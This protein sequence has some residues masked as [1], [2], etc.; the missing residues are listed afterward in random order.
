MIRYMLDTNTCISVINDRPPELRLRLMQ[1]DPAE[2]SISRIV[3]Y[4]LSFG[5]C[6]SA[7]QEKNQANL[8]HFLS[9]VQVVDWGTEQANTAAEIRCILQR[10]GQPIG[11]YDLLIAAHARSLNAVLVTH[12]TREFTRVDGLRVEDWMPEL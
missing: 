2:V 11:P 9:Y 10:T 7:Q 4:E 6:N 1:L 12:N 3:H 8:N 5:V